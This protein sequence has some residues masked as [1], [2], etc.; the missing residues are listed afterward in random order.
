MNVEQLQHHVEA[1]FAPG[2]LLAVQG[3]A[4]TFSFENDEELLLDPETARRW[5]LESELIDPAATVDEA[6]LA[7]LVEFRALVRSLI[8]AN[9]TGEQDREANVTLGRVAAQHPVPVQ[10]NAEG[11][12]TLDVEPAASIDELIAQM[13]GIVFEAQLDGTFPRLKVC[14]ADDCRWAF[15]DASRNRGGTWCQMEVCGNREKNRTYRARR[16]VPAQ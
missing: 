15:Y 7:K 9:L 11:E 5:L 16:S 6:E 2:A 3:L 12:M 1:K 14:A 10:V 4:N 13:I 8:D